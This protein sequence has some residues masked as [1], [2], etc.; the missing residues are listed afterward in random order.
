[1]SPTRTV[2]TMPSTTRERPRWELEAR[3]FDTL[4]SRLSGDPFAASHRYERLRHRLILFF[5]SRVSVAPEDLAD[6]VIDRLARRLDAG[7]PVA[8]VEAYSLGIA[9][10]VV[11]EQ[12]LLAVREVRPDGAALEN[13]SAPNHTSYEDAADQDR[14]L[15]AMER[16]LARLNP[17]DAELLSRYYLEE[18]ESKIEARRRL[19]EERNL[20]P[21]ALRKRVYQTCCTLRDCIRRRITN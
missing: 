19:A 16:C 7:E 15:T 8:S 20:T 9:R 4:L 2:P 3:A 6:Q 1:M 17:G 5:S 14:M 11:Q 13:I 10:H 21:A 18:G 12:R